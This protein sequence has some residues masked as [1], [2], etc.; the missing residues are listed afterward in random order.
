MKE[1]HG[2]TDRQTAHCGITEL[3]VV[4][5]G[6]KTTRISAF[7]VTTKGNNNCVTKI[8]GYSAP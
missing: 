5:R 8:V 3:W 6:K 4:S 2:Q 1:S 7:L